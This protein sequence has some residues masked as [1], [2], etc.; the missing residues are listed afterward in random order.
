MLRSAATGGSGG[1]PGD[2]GDPVDP[3]E[4]PL[5]TQENFTYLGA[6]KLPSGSGPSKYNFA[7]NAMCV[8]RDGST[9]TLYMRTDAG[10][11]GCYM[12][13]VQVPST[14]GTAPD[15]SDW[16]TATEIQT[17][18]D[19]LHGGSLNSRTGYG[20][21]G[22][23]MGSMV[24]GGRLILGAALQYGGGGGDGMRQFAAHNLTL[25][26]ST[27][28]T[29]TW[30]EMDGDEYWTKKLGGPMCEVPEDW[31]ELIGSPAITGNGMLSTITETSC[32]VAAYGF[33]PD[34][35]S[36]G[37]LIVGTPLLS[38]DTDP[39]SGGREDVRKMSYPNHEAS[40]N[41]VMNLTSRYK[42]VF[43]M[44]GT[45]TIAFVGGHG[46]GPYD[47]GTAWGTLP[48]PSDDGENHYVYDP[49]H[50][51]LGIKGPCAPDLDYA[52]G[53]YYYHQV[54]LYDALDLVAVKNG[55]ERSHPLPYA[56]AYLSEMDPHVIATTIAGAAFDKVSGRLYVSATESGSPAVHVY[57]LSL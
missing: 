24:Y 11:D 28:Y 7:G 14:L 5:L 6:F 49:A 26:S 53:N 40:Q 55:A 20:D 46:R 44:P 32:G 47:Y 9:V 19:V 45:R 35:I 10:D 29:T 8:Y 34:E 39:T 51:L 2:P 37:G 57:Q 23:A 16:P 33:D 18:T 43:W 52:E 36:S 12:G 27:G 31:R 42:G 15:Q 54:W 4:Q 48:L 38:Y 3:E 56:I 1:D 13:Q 50:A 22:Y 25:S 41:D 30:C 17:P 21:G